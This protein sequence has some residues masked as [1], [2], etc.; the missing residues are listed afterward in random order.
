M[1][2]EFEN[3][4]ENPKSMRGVK[5]T[6]DIRKGITEVYVVSRSGNGYLVTEEKF[7]KEKEPTNVFHVTDDH[8]V[9]AG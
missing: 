2:T 3:L 9:K 6:I 7:T 4:K 1:N 5:I 8:V